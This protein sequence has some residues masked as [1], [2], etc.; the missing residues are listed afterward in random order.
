[1]FDHIFKLIEGHQILHQVLYFELF[2]WC[3]E[4]T[5]VKHGLLL[6]EIRCWVKRYVSGYVLG[7]S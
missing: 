3:L 6:S 2:S 1:M 4:M 5:V 7:S